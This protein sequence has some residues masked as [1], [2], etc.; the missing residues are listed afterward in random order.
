MAQLIFTNGKTAE[1]SP[2]NGTDFQL[3]ELQEFVGGHI[4]IVYLRDGRMMIVNEEGKLRA[5]PINREATVLYGA[6][7]VIT[8]NAL[9]CERDEVK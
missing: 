3:E 2:K 8:G 4:E 9:V 6:L 5:L 7:D 1:V